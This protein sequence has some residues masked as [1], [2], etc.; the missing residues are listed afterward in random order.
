MT[1]A[2]IAMHALIV[3]D[4]GA[5]PSARRP[6]WKGCALGTCKNLFDQDK[7]SLTT[8]GGASREQPVR[9]TQNVKRVR[10]TARRP[11]LVCVFYIRPQNMFHLGAI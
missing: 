1:L 8:D 3:F 5:R 2:P 7:S 4:K 10:E 9:Q 6:R 11:E